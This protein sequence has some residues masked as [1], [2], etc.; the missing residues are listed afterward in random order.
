MNTPSQLL[1]EVNNDLSIPLN[2]KVALLEFHKQVEL[3]FREQAH[4]NSTKQTLLE[5]THLT[6]ADTEAAFLRLQNYLDVNKMHVISQ[7]VD[8]GN[9]G[10]QVPKGLIA[11]LNKKLTDALS[12]WIEKKLPSS[13]KP[14]KWITSLKE[15]LKNIDPTLVPRYER[16]IKVGGKVGSLVIIAIMI[17]GVVN[18]FTMGG[19]LVGTIALSLLKLLTDILQGAKVSEAIANATKRLATGAALGG[20]IAGVDAAWPNV[21]SWITGN[22]QALE[23]PPELI[24]QAPNVPEAPGEFG[25]VAVPNEPAAASPDATGEYDPDA[26]GSYDPDATGEYEDATGEYEEPPTGR[27]TTYKTQP[28]ET[29]GSIAQKHG[30]TVADMQAANRGIIQNPHNIG[31]GIDLNI[32]TQ[33]RPPGTKIWTGFDFN[34]WGRR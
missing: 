2:F 18:G 33:V 10:P 24:P 32:P 20:V 11:E 34:R 1:F 7:V 17:I 3:V 15:W 26:T 30:V 4:A 25:A 6:P 31:S 28:G 29:L 23:V 27:P 13:D 8:P 21:V 12:G 14:V 22:A 19:P 9:V 5:F 16:L